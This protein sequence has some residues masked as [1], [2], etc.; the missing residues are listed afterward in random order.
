MKNAFNTNRALFKSIYG[1]IIAKAF[2]LRPAFFANLI[3]IIV[4][5][6]F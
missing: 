6:K 4:K 1:V 3:N 2:N 5:G